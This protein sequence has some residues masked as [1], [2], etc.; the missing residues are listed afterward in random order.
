MAAFAYLFF[1]AAFGL[2]ELGDAFAA[3]EAVVTG[4]AEVARFVVAAGEGC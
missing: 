4:L 1:S 2:L 3:G